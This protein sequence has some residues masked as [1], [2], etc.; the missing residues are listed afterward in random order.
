MLVENDPIRGMRN[1][2]A[3]VF[4]N[5]FLQAIDFGKHGCTIDVPLDLQKEEGQTLAKYSKYLT[6]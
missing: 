2:K 5:A 1:E 6:P 4:A 3:S